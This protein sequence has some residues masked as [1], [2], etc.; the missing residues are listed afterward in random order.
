MVSN[1]PIADALIRIK[2]AGAVFKKSTRVPNTKIVQA[3]LEV[4]KS[5]KWIRDFKVT[6]DGRQIKVRLRYKKGQYP[7]PFIQNVRFYSKPGR[8]WYVKAKEITPVRSGYGIQIISTSK[9]LMTSQEA[10][11][12]GLGGELICEIW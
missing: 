3:I 9:G 11:K 4:L 1:Y 6:A 10:K 2:N 7:I 5:K 12:A 8:R